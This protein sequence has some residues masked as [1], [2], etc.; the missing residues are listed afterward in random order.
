MR[1]ARNSARSL[2]DYCMPACRT[3]A[4]NTCVVAVETIRSPIWKIRSPS[5]NHPSPFALLTINQ[6][7]WTHGKSP[8]SG[9]YILFIRDLTSSN[10]DQVI[11][12]PE[13]RFSYVRLSK[14]ILRWQ[15]KTGYYS[16]FS[17]LFNLSLTD[18]LCHPMLHKQSSWNSVDKQP[19]INYHPSTHW[20]SILH[21]LSTV[22]ER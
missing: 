3:F 17:H 12:C 1:I 19:R 22:D 10:L 14:R 21:T 7:V 15:F 13:G 4:I 16:Y 5:D 2:I 9:Y 6:S 11:C 8:S 18:P 20:Y